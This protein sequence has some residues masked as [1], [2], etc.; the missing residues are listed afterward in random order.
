M[1]FG[2]GNE[3]GLDG[4]GEGFEVGMNVGLDEGTDEGCGNGSIEGTYV[5]FGM[6]NCVGAGVGSTEDSLVPSVVGV[7]K[8]STVGVFVGFEAGSGGMSAQH[9]TPMLL[10][11]ASQLGAVSNRV[12]P[13]AIKNPSVHSSLLHTR[14]RSKLHPVPLASLFS[15]SA[16]V[17][18]RAPVSSQN[19]LAVVH[20]TVP[21]QFPEASSLS[22]QTLVL[23]YSSALAQPRSPQLES[24][25]KKGAWYLCEPLGWLVG[26]RDGCGVGNGSGCGVGFGS[27]T[28]V[29]IGVGSRGGKSVGS[30]VGTEDGI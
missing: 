19:D 8:G 30:S 9:R 15:S 22:L 24:E 6:G 12:D 10:R 20:S 29:G 11:A 18:R 13:G 27:G 17:Q 16:T 25:I 14:D 23:P 28:G 5:G 4:L 3:V 2:E 7:G 26:M 21:L 1:G